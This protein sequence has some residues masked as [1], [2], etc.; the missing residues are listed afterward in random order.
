MEDL[1][2]SWSVS[3]RNREK[4]ADDGGKNVKDFKIKDETDT[5]EETDTVPAEVVETEEEQSDVVSTEKYESPYRYGGGKYRYEDDD[6][7]SSLEGEIIV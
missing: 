4:G 3:A 7:D 1:G 5:E 6:D 2:F